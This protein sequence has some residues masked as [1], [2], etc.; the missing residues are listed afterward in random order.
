MIKKISLIKASRSDEKGCLVPRKGTEKDEVTEVGLQ[1]KERD[2]VLFHVVFPVF[3][4]YLSTKTKMGCLNRKT[5][6]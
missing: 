5:K 6:T 3:L 1:D 4:A 2:L